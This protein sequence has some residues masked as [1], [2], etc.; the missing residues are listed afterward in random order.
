[1]LA[2]AVTREREMALRAALGA[3]RQRLVR[4][5]LI[6]SVTLAAIG[7]VLGCAGAA[8]AVRLVRAY[9]PQDIGRLE[10]A[11]IH[12]PVAMFALAVSVLTG[13]VFGLAPAAAAGRLN[14]GGTLKEGGLG[15]WSSVRGTRLRGAFV[16]AQVGLAVVLLT[17]AALLIESLYRLS[18]VPT[19]FDPH[20]VLTGSVIIGSNVDDVQLDAMC[21]QVKQRLTNLPGVENAGFITWLPFAGLGAATDFSVVGR[22]PAPPG[23]GLGAE[24]RVV[25]PGYFETMRIPLL[26]GRLFT[27]SDDRADAAQAFVVNETLVRQTFGSRDPIGQSLIVDMGDDKPGHIVGVVGDAKSTSLERAFQ[28]MVYYVQAQLPISMGTFVLRTKGRPEAMAEALVGAI[29]EVRKD[30]PVT[31]VRTMDDWIGRS[32][33]R[34]R[35]QTALLASFALIALT[36]A[37]IGVYGV[38]AYSVE[39]RTHEIGV[40]LALGAEPRALQGWITRQGMRLAAAGLSESSADGALGPPGRARLRATR[41]IR[42]RSRLAAGGP[43]P[44]DGF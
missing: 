26:R 17:S 18:S 11:G 22:P 16:T 20:H 32:L 7:G 13:I 38:M 8:A 21:R 23:Q 9:G 12:L 41:G 24:V 5:L 14:L 43:G 15:V 40:R 44:R 42:R 4:L 3:T 6:E 33:A 25:Q 36:L 1:M 37:V 10:T 2:R 19:G 30:Q 35:F 34:Q 29:H 31:D 27:E 39:Q 28:P